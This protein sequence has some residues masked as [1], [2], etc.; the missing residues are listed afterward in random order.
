MTSEHC[1]GYSMTLRFAAILLLSPRSYILIF[2][3]SWFC[4][5]GWLNS[6]CCC[7][8]IVSHSTVY[9]GCLRKERSAFVCQTTYSWSDF[10]LSINKEDKNCWTWIK[11]ANLGQKLGCWLFGHKSLLC[12]YNVIIKYFPIPQ[13]T[14]RNCW[15]YPGSAI[16]VIFI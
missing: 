10:T 11:L 8:Q 16:F 4:L 9:C 12:N 14:A 15:S 6:T 1:S 2:F 5:C 3:T 13:T 7:L